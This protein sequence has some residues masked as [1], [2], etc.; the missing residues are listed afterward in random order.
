MPS[1]AHVVDAL[2]TQ[3]AGYTMRILMSEALAYP[4]TLHVGSHNYANLFVEHGHEVFWLGGSLHLGNLWRAARGDAEEQRYA[5]VWRQGGVQVRAGLTTY[6]PLT[7]LPYRKR[8]PFDSTWVMHNTLRATT[9]P[10]RGVLQRHGFAEPDVLWLSQSHSTPS[11]LKLLNPR[12]VIYRMSDRFVDF[13]FVPHSMIA[14]EREVIARA[15][16]V[17]VTAHDLYEEVRAFGG[18][19]VVYLPNGADVE[20]FQ[21]PAPEPHDLRAIPHPR[22]LYAGALHEWFDVPLYRRVAELLPDYH[23]VLVGPC[24]I[25][26]SALTA[27]PN[28]HVLGARPFEQMPAYMWACDVGTI[29]FQLTRMTHSVNP[30]KLFEY[31]ATG[32][33]VVS[34]PMREVVQLHAPATLADNA[35]DFAAAIRDVVARGRGQADYQAFAAANSWRARYAQIAARL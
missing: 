25:D 20:R 9:P 15:E 4:S 14:A 12:K 7:W 8:A 32:L 31:L 2:R 1:A 10:L 21:A 16:V 24:K 26:L 29:P 6:H 13:G 33:G 17:F 28:V 3:R 19:K 5:D 23:F 34:V 18:D 30:I 11:L 22:V 35:D 27:L